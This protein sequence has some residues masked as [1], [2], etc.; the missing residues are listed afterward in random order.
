MGRKGK[1]KK[2]GKVSKGTWG[3]IMRETCKFAGEI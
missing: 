1:K 2:D 3:Q